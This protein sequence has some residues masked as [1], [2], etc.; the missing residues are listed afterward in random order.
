MAAE[1]LGVSQLASRYATALFELADEKQD[2]DAV[3]GDL[4]KVRDLLD[5]SADLRAA[6]RSPL[7]ARDAQGRA[8]ADV[9]DKAGVGQTVRNFVGV[10]ANHRRLAALPD[11]IRAFLAELARRRGDLTARVVSARP[12][13]DGQAQAVT[14]SLKK[15]MGAKVSVDFQVDPDILGGLV[16]H[17]GSR[18][19]DS[20][21]RTRLQKMQLA[22][23]GA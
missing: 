6:I 12:L 5:A 18:M 1:G 8:L 4:Q 9:L 13:D 10:V 14:D 23:K 22:M 16:V 2:L 7:I 15:S 17:V 21:V 11:M 19:I 3:A 20:S